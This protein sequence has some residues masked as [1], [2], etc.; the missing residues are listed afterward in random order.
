MY[1]NFQKEKRENVALKIILLRDKQI[2]N[3]I[4]FDDM[5]KEAVTIISNYE[6]AK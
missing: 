1:A 4:S 3:K 6:N 5:L 2:N